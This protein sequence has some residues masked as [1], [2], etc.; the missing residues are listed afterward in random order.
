[1]RLIE[2]VRSLF[3]FTLL[4]M[5]GG[6]CDSCRPEPGGGAGMTKAD[7]A[8]SGSSS[9][10]SVSTDPAPSAS[11]EHVNVRMDP[12]SGIT[13]NDPRFNKLGL[14]DKLVVEKENRP[15]DTLKA[16]TVFDAVTGKLGIKLTN[17][18]QLAA[19]P[20]HASY[21]EKA[22]TDLGVDVSVCE[23][24]DGAS[25]DKGKAI[26]DGTKT[27]RREILRTKTTWVSLTRFSEGKDAEAQAKRISD[28]VKGL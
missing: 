10:S 21:C 27:P 14:F 22:D 2:P 6:G 5:L 20:V 15:K 19:W 12:D 18:K 28:L 7:A 4:C 23:F 8:A 13:P 11:D 26:A 3:I 16:E 1:M 17:R 9:S 25:F 24:Q